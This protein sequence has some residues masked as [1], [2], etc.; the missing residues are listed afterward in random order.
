LKSRLVHLDS[1]AIVKRY[2][3]EAGSEEVCELYDSALA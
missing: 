3:E 1:S 2:V